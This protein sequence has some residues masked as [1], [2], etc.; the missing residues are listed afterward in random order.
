MRDRTRMEE[1]GKAK[2]KAEEEK[3]VYREMLG[4]AHERWL[5]ERQELFRDALVRRPAARILR[6]RVG[7]EA[8]PPLAEAAG[9]RCGGRT[10]WR[11][12]RSACASCRRRRPSSRSRCATRRSSRRRSRCTASRRRPPFLALRPSPARPSPAAPTAPRA[13]SRPPPT[14]PDPPLTTGQGAHRAAHRLRRLLR[15]YWQRR[16]H[17]GA[18]GARGRQRAGAHAALDARQRGARARLGRRRL[19]RADGRHVAHIQNVCEGGGPRLERSAA[20]ATPASAPSVP[21][22]R[23]LR[24]AGSS[25]A[26]GF[27]GTATAAAAP[28]PSAAPDR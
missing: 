26:E 27:L 4:Q 24:Q 11:T 28:P 19:A 1:M 13:P 10:R 6:T 18:H 7:Q 5:R 25:I 20:L 23:R 16:R 15:R 21:H 3:N 9:A 8:D 14:S 17:P 22:L 2:N 12:T